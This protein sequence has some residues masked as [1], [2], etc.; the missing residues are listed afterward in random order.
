M[1]VMDIER[2]VE[3][4]RSV[5][6]YLEALRAT[7]SLCQQQQ[8]FTADDIRAKLE[9]QGVPVIEPSSILAAVIQ[10][11]SRLG[12]CAQTARRVRSE[13]KAAHR[14][15]LVVWESAGL[16]TSGMP[17]PAWDGTP[18][19]VS[20]RL[21]RKPRSRPPTLL[22]ILAEVHWLCEY[23]DIF[24]I[25]D[26]R[27]RMVISEDRAQRAVSI[28][29]ARGWCRPVSNEHMLYGESVAHWRSARVVPQWDGK[30]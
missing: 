2:A 27:K 14:R 3:E 5:D 11:A 29:V 1:V 15:R 7:Y 13:R 8:H 18:P 22:A 4:P 23:K 9:G 20:H 16:Q 6:L 26:V 30:S 10:Q 28:A 12:W 21:R 19:K 24:G 17:L 25:D